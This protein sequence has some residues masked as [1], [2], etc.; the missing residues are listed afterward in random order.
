MLLSMGTLSCM[1]SFICKLEIYYKRMVITYFVNVVFMF[2]CTL[3]SVVCFLVL[4]LLL[5]F[6]ISVVVLHFT[7]S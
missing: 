3:Y 1:G 6:V 7:V 5:L 2:L 4:S